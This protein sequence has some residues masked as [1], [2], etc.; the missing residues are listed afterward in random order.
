MSDFINA[1]NL[2][3]RGTPGNVYRDATTKELFLA[4]GDGTLVSIADLLS[5]RNIRAVGPQG[6]TGRQ[7]EPGPQGENGLPGRDGAP[8]PVGPTGP[9]GTNGIS[10]TGK[11]GPQGERGLTGPAGPQGP[12]GI[13]GPVG[14]QGP[15]GDILYCSQAEVEAA[16]LRLHQEKVRIRAAFLNSLIRNEG[17]SLSVRKHWERHVENIMREAGL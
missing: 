1:R 2:P 16:A 8:G 6:E 15:P 12:Q 13:A 4:V 3:S 14:P 11:T 7:G 9:H 10:I 17:V 5:E